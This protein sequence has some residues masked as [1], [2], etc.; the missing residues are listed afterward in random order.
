M[1]ILTFLLTGIFMLSALN[2]PYTSTLI[3]STL[4]R[5]TPLLSAAPTGD[6]SHRLPWSNHRQPFFPRLAA[7]T[8]IADDYLGEL[9]GENNPYSTEPQELPQT[10]SADLIMKITSAATLLSSVSLDTLV[11]LACLFVLRAICAFIVRKFRVPRPP[12]PMFD[13]IKI[14]GQAF[15]P[16]NSCEGHGLRQS[17][18]EE[19]LIPSDQDEL[20]LSEGQLI[21][22]HAALK[23]VSVIPVEVPEPGL[24]EDVLPEI[25][26]LTCATSWSSS[27]GFSITLDEDDCKLLENYIELKKCD[28][29]QFSRMSLHPSVHLSHLPPSEIRAENVATEA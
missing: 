8:D 27:S 1:F 4:S 10:A 28:L 24:H 12:S 21:P 23:V 25:P 17:L 7:S 22:A 29:T 14:P 9:S 18:S 19:A 11:F 3:T 13:S 26:E 2:P 20:V 15:T 5:H 6:S 16:S